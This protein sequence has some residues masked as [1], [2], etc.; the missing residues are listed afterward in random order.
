MRHAD[1]N[2]LI[3]GAGS[4]IGRET[5]LRLAGEGARILVTDVSADGAAE[6]VRLIEE[7]GGSALSAVVDV[8]SREQIRAAVDLAREAWGS[9]HLLVNNAGVVTEHSFETLTEEA[10]D[11][12]FDINLKGQFL[13][14]QEVAPLIAESGGGAIVNLSTVEALVVVTSTGTAQPHYNAS[15][16]GVPMLTKALAVE[17]AGKNIRVNCVAPG[18]IATDFFDYESVTS[19][20][21][22]EFMK[23]RL[24]VPRVGQPA[25]IAA[26]V[27][28]L[29]SEEASWIDGIQLPVDGGWLTR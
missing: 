2:A 1:K 16:G 25:D 14:A 6:T 26:A 19:A 13:V 3:T 4:G 20:E 18:P 23:Q 15:K 17:L 12:V 27:S 9:L 24:L 7:A 28:W 5:A 21:A 29:L 10:W 11:F 22:L 8:R